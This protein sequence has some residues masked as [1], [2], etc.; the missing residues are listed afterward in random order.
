M[1]TPVVGRG[2]DCTHTR[3]QKAKTQRRT[4]LCEKSNSPRRAVRGADVQQSTKPFIVGKA[5]PQ[6]DEG[7]TLCF[8]LAL[9]VGFMAAQCPNQVNGR[10][11]SSKP[12][13]TNYTNYWN[14]C[15]PVYNVEYSGDLNASGDEHPTVL[16]R[17]QSI[18]KVR[19][20]A[21]DLIFALVFEKSLV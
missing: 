6:D 17:A 9:L 4:I 21:N 3:K 15:A 10:I 5:I 18:L 14:F 16:N 19:N 13:L 2:P 7:T 12:K 20:L 8:C 1:H 11:V